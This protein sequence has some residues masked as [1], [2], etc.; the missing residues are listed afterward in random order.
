MIALDLLTNNRLNNIFAETRYL[1]IEIVMGIQQC[2]P[3]QKR[4]IPP[5]PPPQQKSDL[6]LILNRLT[7]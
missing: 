5:L 6:T 4:T 7:L 1:K 2:T 3:L